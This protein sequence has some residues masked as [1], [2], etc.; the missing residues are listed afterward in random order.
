MLNAILKWSSRQESYLGYYAS[1]DQYYAG[2]HAFAHLL[3]ISL[4][5]PKWEIWSTPSDQFIPNP[6]VIVTGSE[7]GY[8]HQDR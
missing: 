2:Q 8:M 4:P 7:M 1:R 6:K 3:M 5:D